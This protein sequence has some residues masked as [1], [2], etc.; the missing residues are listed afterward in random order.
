MQTFIGR[1]HAPKWFVVSEVRDFDDVSDNVSA[2][3][4]VCESDVLA[5]LKHC[6]ELVFDTVH[7]NLIFVLHVST[8]FRNYV[9]FAIR[10]YEESFDKGCLLC[11]FLMSLDLVH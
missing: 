8:F 2:V 7:E 3:V 1:W 5:N 11:Y 6:F 9:R 4:I 10:L